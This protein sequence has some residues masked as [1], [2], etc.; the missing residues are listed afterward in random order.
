MFFGRENN[1]NREAPLWFAVVW[2]S[3]LA[4]GAFARSAAPVA[5]LYSKDNAIAVYAPPAKA[6]Y[7]APVLVFVDRT[8]ESFQRTLRLKLGSQACPLEIAVGS[9]S[10]GDTRVLTARL[11]DS[12]G[13]VRERIELPD[14][15][16]AD[17]TRFRRAVCVALLRAWMVDAGG[18]DAT[19][20]N[21]PG[22]LVDGLIRYMDRDV[23]QADLDRTLLL[24]SHACL[25]AAAELFAEDSLAAVREPAI[26][27]V[28]ASWFLEKQPEGNAHPFEALLRGAATGTEW[29]T[30]R[31]ALLLS[32][33]N[34]LEALDASLDAWLLSGGRQV[35]K[36]GVTT[37]G[38]V[39][40]FRAHLLLYPSDCGKTLDPARVALA[41]RE[42]VPLSDDPA[43][44]YGAL[45]QATNIK[46]AALGRDGMLLAVSEAYADFLREFAHG[47]KPAELSRLLTEAEKMRKELEAR[48]ANGAVLKQP[49]DG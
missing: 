32:G 45:V 49:T 20:K 14:P 11:R 26:A 12:G 21:L 23:R 48:T 36:P 5:P 30:S 10:D 8:R 25:P 29:S 44:R 16:A 35:L 4:G 42:M 13:G 3:L 1:R 37:G 15:E 18:T 22:W 9:K 40:R 46:M 7:R 47:A 2:G 31:A 34:D 17:L 24:W 28:L 43:I 38:I 27:A 41:F 39:R 6:G 19:M 33:K